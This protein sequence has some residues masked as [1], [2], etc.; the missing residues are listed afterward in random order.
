[1]VMNIAS[2]IKRTLMYFHKTRDIH[3]PSERI[4]VW[5]YKLMY[6]IG[7]GIK[8]MSYVYESCLAF[9]SFSFILTVLFYIFFVSFF[10]SHSKYSLA[11]LLWLFCNR[12]NNSILSWLP[13][14]LLSFSTK[15]VHLLISRHILKL[16][17]KPPFTLL[18]LWN[19]MIHL[20]CPI[21]T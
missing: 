1:M 12:I 11:N 18:L 7:K 16:L 6:K 15:Q 19:L 8:I 21:F 3:S 5:Q 10:F 9:T 20:V 4:R 2:N 13:V 14:T 17:E